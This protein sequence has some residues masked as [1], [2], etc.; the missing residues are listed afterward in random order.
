MK[1]GDYIIKP[2]GSA[3]ADIW[4]ITGIYLGG[5][6]HQNIIGLQTI[7]RK[8]GSDGERTVTEMLCPL[9]LCEPYLMENTNG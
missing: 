9:E 6:G 2:R 5:V 3:E 1:P 4:R 8:D 7:N